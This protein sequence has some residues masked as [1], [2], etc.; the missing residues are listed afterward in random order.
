MNK[1]IKQSFIAIQELLILFFS[2]TL[3]I[4]C[5]SSE[6]QTEQE[7]QYREELLSKLYSIR[8]EDS[9]K[10]VLQRFVEENNDVGKMITYKQLGFRQRENAR[11]SDAI[12]SHQQSLQIALKLKDTLEIVQAMNNLGTNF[13]RIGAHGEASQYHYQAL[14]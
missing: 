14:N 8:S 2:I 3:L 4:Q 13:R 1:V 9:L 6:V 5:T 10:I 7:S 11:F 12:S